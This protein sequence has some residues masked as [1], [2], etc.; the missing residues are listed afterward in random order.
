MKR[1]FYIALMATVAWGCDSKKKEADDEAQKTQ[2]AAQVAAEDAGAAEAQAV[3]FVPAEGWTVI[4]HNSSAALLPEELA[5]ARKAQ[6]HLGIRLIG[7]L[8]QAVNSKGAAEAVKVCNTDVA[9][10]REGVE[11]EFGVEVGRTSHKIRNPNNT[12]PDFVKPIVEARY[13]EPVAM[14]GP[15]K[16]VGWVFP[17]RTGPL[18]AQCHGTDDK[19]APG[20]EDKLAE[21]YP[22]DQARGFEVGELRGWVWAKNSPES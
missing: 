13:A 1:A 9:G 6:G 4:D 5:A 7:T 12:P 22:E 18:C 14:I 17:L 19:L 10:I 11:A 20:V 15:N 16:E 2:T 3:T 21:L 8:S